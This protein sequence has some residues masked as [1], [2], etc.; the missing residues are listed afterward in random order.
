MKFKTTT[1]AIKAGYSKIFKVG[2]CELN[3][4]LAC[5]EPVAY[6]CGIY[7]WNYDVYNVGSVAICTGYRGMPGTRPEYIA[8]FEKRAR[9]LCQSLQWN[10]DARKSA[11]EKLLEQFIDANI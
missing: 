10:Y 5:R 2:Y 11:L 3:S 4:L 9:D 6:T 1:K 8:E 7:G